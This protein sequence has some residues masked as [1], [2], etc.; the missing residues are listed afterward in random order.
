MEFFKLFS[1][2][3]Q[4]QKSTNPSE[5]LDFLQNSCLSTAVEMLLD[6]FTF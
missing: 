5:P 2:F 6:K 4:K 3:L 1:F